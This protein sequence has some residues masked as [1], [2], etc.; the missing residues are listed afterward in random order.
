[1]KRETFVIYL[2]SLYKGLPGGASGK[3]S[4]CQGRRTNI[5]KLKKCQ[6]HVM[7]RT[8]L[9]IINKNYS[10]HGSEMNEMD[11]ESRNRLDISISIQPSMN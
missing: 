2:P 10:I 3:E 9:L 5:F 7:L 1:M 6:F 11:E 8:N 4:L